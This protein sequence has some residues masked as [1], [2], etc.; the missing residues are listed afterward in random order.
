VL[1]ECSGSRLIIL[2]R[3]V[4]L[5]TA[6]FPLQLVLF[7]SGSRA[8]NAAEPSAHRSV[9]TPLADAL[10]RPVAIVLRDDPP[11]ILVANREGTLAVIDGASNKL[12][13]EQAV[14][15]RLSHAVPLDRG[16][17]LLVADEASGV[18]VLLRWSGA[19][20]RQEWSRSVCHSP[21]ALMPAADD[22]SVC[23]ASLWGR[24]L[25]WMALEAS[26][27][28][29]VAADAARDRWSTDFLDLPFAPRRLVRLSPQRIVAIDAF[30]GRLAVV[31][32]ISRRLEFEH[33]LDAH[34][35]GG[36]CLSHDQTHLLVTHQRLSSEEPTTR[37]NV[38]WGEV[39]RNVVR[40]LPVDWLLSSQKEAP[41]GG[42]FFLGY[43]DSATGDPGAILE[44]ADRRQIVALAGISQVGISDV[45][46][47][48]FRQIDVG[49]R[50]IALAVS[51]RL[52]RLYVACM[53]S[54]SLDVIDLERGERSA[55]VALRTSDTTS[56]AA[57]GEQLFY[58]AR[59][60]S[61]GWYSC[62]SCHTEGHSNGR[63]N[64]NGTDGSY[65]DPKRVLSLLGTA[66]T[67]PWAW[68]GRFQELESQ[69]RHSIESTM[70]G[71]APS[72]DDLRAIA[73]FLRTLPPAPSLAEAR[74]LGKPPARDR[75]HEHARERGQQLFERSGCANCHAPTA[76]TTP[77]SY[78]VGLHGSQGDRL[79]NPPSLRGVSQ[80]ERLF[81]DN[82]AA[83]L[84][85]VFEQFQHG[86]DNPPALSQLDDLL[87]F[88]QSL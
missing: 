31:N 70:Q 48:Y 65:G 56:L 36:A 12:L 43:P 57:R 4:A 73:A 72:E 38:H 18:L 15:E 42:L 8:L 71:P 59:L 30:G 35:I 28:A 54:D 29:A 75:A 39:M 22:R 5:L 46:A 25:Y 82:R 55:T 66:D 78:D 74:R 61:D 62:H 47:N 10:R 24:R 19:A 7:A 11:E 27:S 87:S 32:E 14:G 41:A 60:S 50:P 21:V 13:H 44:T 80:R 58:D 9:T 52:Q 34:N 64:D 88:L 86:L 84:R 51:P 79:F 20:L 53:N 6:L 3:L 63:L 76:Y 1:I 81:H 16:Q 23:V 67:A 45:G 17:K 49:N 77:D 2:N 33:E 85:A 37:S 83:N 26:G 68:N 69:I 40:R